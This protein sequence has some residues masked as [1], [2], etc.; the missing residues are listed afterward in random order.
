MARA[1][2]TVVVP[3]F[4][5]GYRRYL[6]ICLALSVSQLVSQLVRPCVSIFLCL[7][8]Q[9]SNCLIHFG[10]TSG[11]AWGQIRGSSGGSWTEDDL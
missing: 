10:D 6:A 7:N 11:V 5:E 1:D 3:V 2:S 9:A 4:S 8:D